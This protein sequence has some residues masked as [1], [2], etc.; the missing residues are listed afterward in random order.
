MVVA[1]SVRLNGL[2]SFGITKLDV[3]TGLDNL[4]ICVAYELDGEQISH[5]PASLKKLAR[6]KPVYKEMPGW[7]EDITKA[8]KVGD[9]PANARAYLEAIEEETKTPISIVSVG[10]GREETIMVDPV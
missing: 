8:R 3:L 6:C 9:L 4:K 7:E 10:A 5:R 1:D 2:S